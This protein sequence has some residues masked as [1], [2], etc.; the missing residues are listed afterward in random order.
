MKFLVGDGEQLGGQLQG[1][2]WEKM[3]LPS[4]ILIIGVVKDD[5]V[6]AACGIR[7]ILNQLTIYVKEGYRGRGIGRIMFDK[8]FEL[9]RKRGVDFIMGTISFWQKA[10]K[11]LGSKHEYRPLMPVDERK[12][13]IVIHPFTPR[14]YLV[15]VFLRMICIIVPSFLMAR[16]LDFVHNQIT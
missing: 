10:S 6:V 9:A 2:P 5:T 3:L 12:I 15:Y 7:S 4:K 11:R 16:I 1:F 8:M 13:T 14:G